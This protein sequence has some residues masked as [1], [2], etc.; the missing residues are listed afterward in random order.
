MKKWSLC[1]N[2]QGAMQSWGNESKLSFRSTSLMPTRSGV[3]GIIASALGLEREDEKSLFELNQLRLATVS[4]DKK[5]R[6]IERDYHTILNVPKASGGIKDT[7][8][9][10]RLYLADWQFLALIE[11]EKEFLE[12]IQIAL[13]Y[14][15]WLT[16]LGR[17][18][19]PPAAPFIYGNALKEGQLEHILPQDGEFQCYKEALPSDETKNLNKKIEFDMPVSFSERKF[20][21]RSFY[22]DWVDIKYIKDT[23]FPAQGEI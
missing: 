23:I 7:E 10:L 12:K 1:I 11:G 20:K 15:K 17:K 22:E 4:L 16:F 9:S 6:P 14:P 3:T 13:Q 19:F 2:L 8:L 5:I 21:Q 18:S